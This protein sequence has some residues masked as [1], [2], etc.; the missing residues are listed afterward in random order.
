M[1][2]D[3]CLHHVVTPD[4]LSWTEAR[5]ECRRRGYDLLRIQDREQMY[6]LHRRLL[7]TTFTDDDRLVYIGKSSV[8]PSRYLAVYVNVSLAE[9]CFGTY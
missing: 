3:T 7:Y 8:F 5:D 4:R 1:P 6:H 9:A 2:V